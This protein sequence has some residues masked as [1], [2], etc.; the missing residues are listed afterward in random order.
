MQ[1]ENDYTNHC[2][3]IE[4]VLAFEIFYES[5]SFSIDNIRI[6]VIIFHLS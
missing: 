2:N 4:Q 3:V 1:K 5:F 6:C